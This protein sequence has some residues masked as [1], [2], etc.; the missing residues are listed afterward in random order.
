MGIS[1]QNGNVSSTLRYL[2]AFY[3]IPSTDICERLSSL[4]NSAA[5]SP[6]LLIVLAHPDDEVLAVGGRLERMAGLE[7][8]PALPVNETASR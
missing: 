1:H 8:T 6:R 2:R 3:P 7:L 4:L 5:V